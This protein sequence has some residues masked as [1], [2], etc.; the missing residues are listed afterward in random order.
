MRQSEFADLLVVEGIY[1]TRQA[2]LEAVKCGKVK[3]NN[4]VFEDIPQVF[5][6]LDAY[7]ARQEEAQIDRRTNMERK[8]WH[9]ITARQAANID[10]D[11]WPAIQRSFGHDVTGNN[12]LRIYIY[13]RGTTVKCDKDEA[14]AYPSLMPG[15]WVKDT[16]GRWWQCYRAEDRPAEG[17]VVFYNADDEIVHK[18]LPDAEVFI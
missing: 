6:V 8:G 13:V 16:H 12:R 15:Q 18:L 4:V 17:C 1:S 9:T 10:E 7:M 2:A 5:P 11:L 14:G 3:M